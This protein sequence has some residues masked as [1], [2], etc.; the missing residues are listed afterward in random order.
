[1]SLDR[2][3]LSGETA[4]VR[5]FTAKQGELNYETRIHQKSSPGFVKFCI[6]GTARS[7]SKEL[8]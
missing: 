5:I 4:S 2:E 3:K 6:C 7:T 1:M 8:L